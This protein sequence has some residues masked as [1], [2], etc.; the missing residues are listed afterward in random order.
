MS[1]K[2]FSLDSHLDL[3][4]G[5]EMELTNRPIS[6]PTA[7]SVLLEETNEHDL[8]KSGMIASNITILQIEDYSKDSLTFF[9]IYI[10]ITNVLLFALMDME[11][12]T[13]NVEFYIQRLMQCYY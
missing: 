5:M 9:K 3:V 11:C 10:I 12:K 6:E 2:Q 4:Q 1:G 8:S 7:A 13:I